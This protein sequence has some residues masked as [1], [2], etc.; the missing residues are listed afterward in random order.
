MPLSRA[1]IQRRYRERKKKESGS[2]LKKDKER[3]RKNYVPV[4]MLSEPEAKKRRE[5]TNKRVK[6]HYKKKKN[7]NVDNTVHMENEPVTRQSTSKKGTKLTVSVKFEKTRKSKKASNLNKMK[8]LYKSISSLKER[9]EKLIRTKKSL[10]KK[11]QRIESRAQQGTQSLNDE[12][13]RLTPRSE[14]DKEMRSTGVS[15]RQKKIIRR[16]LLFLNV[17]QN[18]IKRK[19]IKVTVSTIEI[20]KKYRQ[21]KALEEAATKRTKNP[22]CKA[23]EDHSHKQVE[24]ESTEFSRTRR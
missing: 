13:E 1:E 5:E 18:E 4:S 11:L 17:L 14:T 9:N 23:E 3:K 7:A 24:N 21:M 2:F 16:K 12:L 6:K 10:Q 19:S 20:V 22:E 15:P 8:S